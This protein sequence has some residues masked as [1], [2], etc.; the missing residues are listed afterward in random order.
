MPK[1]LPLEMVVRQAVPTD[2]PSMAELFISAPGDGELYQYP[3]F[4]NHLDE[5]AK[6]HIKWLCQVICDS[7]MSMRV[8]AILVPGK[9]DRTVGFS[10]WKKMDLDKETGEVRAVE[11]VDAK[12]THAHQEFLARLTSQFESGPSHMLQPDPIHA[13]AISRGRNKTM[14]ASP[15]KRTTH[16]ELCGLAVHNDYQGHGIGSHLVQWGLDQAAEERIPVF[17]GGEGRGVGFYESAFGFRRLKATE[18]WLDGE[19]RDITREEVEVGNEDWRREK[20]GVSGADS[21][22]LPEGIDDG[23]AAFLKGYI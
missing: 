16:Y 3:N 11:L 4:S 19:G 13:E 15:A 12:W 5:M 7:T 21:V 18:Y 2:I 23:L 17:V 10:G 22:W 9:Q 1:N 20:G 14:L 8:A 6:V